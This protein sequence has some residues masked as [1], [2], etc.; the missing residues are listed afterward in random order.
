MEGAG[1]Q[2][3]EHQVWAARRILG[4]S[5]VSRQALEKIRGLSAYAALG[6]LQAV[7]GGCSPPTFQPPLPGHPSLP[8]AASHYTFSPRRPFP[9]TSCFARAQPSIRDA[10]SQTPQ[11]YLHLPKPH[12]AS[13]SVPYS[14]RGLRTPGL[15]SSLLPFCAP[16][17]IVFLLYHL[18]S[19]RGM[20]LCRA[21]VLL[22][23]VEARRAQS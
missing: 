20:G 9:H 15:E 21:G 7:A 11:R 4:S 12:P 19:A 8:G 16:A 5:P 6:S 2:S 13:L 22:K 3:Q 14:G 10:F 1:S 17:A 18:P 23:G